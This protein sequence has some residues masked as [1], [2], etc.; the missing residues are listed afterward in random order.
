MK[1]LFVFFIVFF[2]LPCAADELIITGDDCSVIAPHVPDD[3]VA[4]KP[5]IDADGMDVEPADLNKSEIAMPEKISIPIILEFE[6]LPA[7]PPNGTVKIGTL[8]HQAGL[9]TLTFDTKTKDLYFNNKLLSPGNQH[10]IAEA[11][12]KIR[13][14]K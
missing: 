4:Y 10:A 12:G 8:K 7:S 13:S 14:N 2:A 1:F 11:C 3:D 6:K 5:G 9:G